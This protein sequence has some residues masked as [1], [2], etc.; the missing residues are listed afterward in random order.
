MPHVTLYKLWSKLLGNIKASIQCLYL[1][2]YLYL[3]FIFLGYNSKY[4]DETTYK[5]YKKTKTLDTEIK[6][7]KQPRTITQKKQCFCRGVLQTEWDTCK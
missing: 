6:N 3:C 2:L 7:T 5:D 1:Y 4:T